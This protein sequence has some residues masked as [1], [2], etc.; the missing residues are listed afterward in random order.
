[1]SW[2]R[3]IETIE[4]AARTCVNRVQIMAL[5][6]SRR[7]TDYLLRTYFRR[8]TNVSDCL[9][10]S[11]RSCQGVTDTLSVALFR[12][13]EHA[14]APIHRS[15]SVIASAVGQA[16]LDVSNGDLAN[17]VEPSFES[18]TFVERE[19]D[20]ILQGITFLHLL[21]AAVVRCLR[22]WL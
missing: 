17:C 7:N 14:G 15:C 3:V 19:A 6:H 10:S 5:S 11:N 22:G 20:G 9:A 21:C 4:Q 1:M 16:V 13:L 2:L 18:G 12:G 8:E